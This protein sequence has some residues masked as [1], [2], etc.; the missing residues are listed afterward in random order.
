MV[1]LTGDTDPDVRDKAKS[2][3]CSHIPIEEKMWV[4]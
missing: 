1:L 3:L 4:I 2:Y